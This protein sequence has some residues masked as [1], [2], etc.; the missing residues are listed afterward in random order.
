MITV[1]NDPDGK[2]GDHQEDKEDLL[3]F[4]KIVVL[5]QIDHNEIMIPPMPGGNNYDSITFAR[6]RH[7]GCDPAL[8][9]AFQEPFRSL[10]RSFEK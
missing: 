1:G 8:T 4:G 10:K 6:S 3:L 5:S 7:I 9:E 2:P